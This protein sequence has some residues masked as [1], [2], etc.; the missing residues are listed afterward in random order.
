MIEVEVKKGDKTYAR[1]PSPIRPMVGDTLVV[2]AQF[3]RPFMGNIGDAETY[4]FGVKSVT[5]HKF[6]N[7]MKVEV[8][9]P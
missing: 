7:Y 9:C 8:Q 2:E 5:I 6:R 4:R 1:F 3:V